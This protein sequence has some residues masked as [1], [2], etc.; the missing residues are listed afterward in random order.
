MCHKYCGENNSLY[1][2]ENSHYWG[3]GHENTRFDDRNCHSF[4]FTCHNKYGHGE[5]RIEYKEWLIKRLGQDGYDRL[6]IDANAYKK[7]D[8][9]MDLII[10]KEKL[11]KLEEEC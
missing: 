3:R 2:L 1:K 7:R 8:D 6:Q 10:I 9:A 4:C 11:R 5:K